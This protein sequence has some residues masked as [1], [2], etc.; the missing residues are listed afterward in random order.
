[1]LGFLDF[2]GIIYQGTT[3][4]ADLSLICLVGSQFQ[5]THTQLSCIQSSLECILPCLS[6]LGTGLCDLAGGSARARPSARIE[7]SRHTVI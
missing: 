3:L 6:L 4:P 2:L 5:S 1:M 7:Y